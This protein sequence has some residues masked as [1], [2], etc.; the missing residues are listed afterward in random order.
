MRS[1]SALGQVCWALCQLKCKDYETI[2]LSLI[3]LGDRIKAKLASWN[4]KT[5]SMTGR[6]FFIK[7]AI[8]GTFTL[9]FIFYLSTSGLVL[10]SNTSIPALKIFS[11]L[12][13]L[14]NENLLVLPG[15]KFASPYLMVA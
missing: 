8:L 11:G 13:P 3:P 14:K 9:F 1:I 6:I 4:C 7:S 2:N 12:F 5:L 15:M 10:S